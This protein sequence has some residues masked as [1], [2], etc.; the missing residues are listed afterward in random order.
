MLQAALLTAPLLPA[1]ALP[2][3]LCRLDG[4]C[5]ANLSTV[6]W[7][8]S[9]GGTTPVHR[10]KANN[11]LSVVL[12]SIQR[13]IAC[14]TFS[15]GHS[16]G[17]LLHCCLVQLLWNSSNDAEAMHHCRSQ[18]WCSRECL[19]R[20]LRF[21]GVLIRWLSTLASAFSLLW[22]PTTANCWAR[23]PATGSFSLPRHPSVL[24]LYS[25]IPPY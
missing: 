20:G 11:G 2:R 10:Q 6:A 3:L 25:S 4:G 16:Q 12:D 17:V 22:R 18:A 15:A 19:P 9:L 23:V 21:C 7:S 8:C 14:H 13:A 5:A 24:L 1:P